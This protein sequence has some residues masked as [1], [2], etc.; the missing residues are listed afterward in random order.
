[1]GKSYKFL[2][3][4]VINRDI[5]LDVNDICKNF[6]ARVTATYNKRRSSWIPISSQSDG[7]ILS[8]KSIKN[9][10]FHSQPLILCIV[11]RHNLFSYVFVA[12]L[13]L[14]FIK[15]IYSILFFS[16]LSLLY[17]SNCSSNNF[18]PKLLR[19][20]ITISSGFSLFLIRFT[21]CS[22]ISNA[23]SV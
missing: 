17:S 7:K 4:S 21:I 19:A 1:M 22:I 18:S 3:I 12:F 13:S 23:C 20:M 14:S 10:I 16:V 15:A 11:A 8:S 5:V 9:T 6:F 2:S